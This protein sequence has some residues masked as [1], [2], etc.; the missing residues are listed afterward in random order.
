MHYFTQRWQHLTCALTAYFRIYEA[1]PAV[2]AGF[3]AQQIHAILQLTPLTMLANALNAL[4][5][6]VI[7]FDSPSFHYVVLWVAVLGYTLFKGTRAWLLQR[8]SSPPERVSPRALTRATQ[9]AAALGIIWAALPILV[10]SNTDAHLTLLLISICVGMLC[11]G[12]FALS[13]VPQAAMAYVLL[14]ALGCVIAFIKDGIAQNWD[15]ALLLLIYS[16]IVCSAVLSSA[17][18]FGARL[19]AEAEAAHQQQLVS[20]LLHD[21]ESHTS[22][23]LWELDHQGVLR[24][25]SQKLV[26]LLGQDATALTQNSFAQLFDTDYARN[27]LVDNNP[28]A[29]LEH[30]LQ[31]QEPFRELVIPIV[32]RGERYWWQLTA[33][34]LLNNKDHFVGWRGV[35]SDVTHKRNAELEMRRLANVDSLTNLAN[36]H[37]FYMQLETLKKQDQFSPFTLFFLDL[38]NFKNVNDSLGH[39]VGDLVLKTVAQR[40][41][42]TVR[43]NDLLA[44]LGGDEFAIISQGEDSATQASILAQRILNTFSTPCVINGKSLPIACSIGIALAPDHGRDTETL[45]KNADMALYAAKSAGRNT[46]RF[47]EHGME[48]VAQQ[49][50]YLLND[51]RAALEEHAATNK[52]LNKNFS[53][54]LVWPQTP[55]V[56][57][58]ELFFQPQVKLSTH[59]VVGFEALIRWHHPELGLIPPAQ[60]IPL[61]EESNLIIPIGTWVLVEACKYAAKWP[62]KWRIAVNL[63]AAQFSEGNVIEVVRWALQISRLE[64]AR[65]ELEITE[66]LLIHDN[67]SAQETLTALRKLGVR[68]ALDDFGTGYSSLAYLRTFPLNKLKIDRSFVSALSQDSS[69]LAIVNAIIQL[70]DALELDTT[71]EGIETQQEADILRSCGCRDAQGFYFSKPLPLQEALAQARQLAP[72]VFDVDRM[73]RK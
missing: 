40:L 53:E 64:P 4:A 6:L 63:S 34:P 29:Q 1:E 18:T 48:I 44:R 10:F 60:F 31:R 66:S 7:F 19:M 23:W 2:A 62:E 43:S 24:N 21:F 55:I 47:Y 3:R 32:I 73:R 20:L 28:I 26:S 52:L 58:F 37:C 56:G 8:N 72:P 61:A 9:H 45:L 70:A 68:I 69:A 30:H 38:D 13:T 22:D 27:E 67:V 36:R 50:L 15:L 5:L 42:K 51:M 49:K 39:G 35:G 11:A 33:K 17:K 65:L 25:P 57:Q 12:G 46:F 71:V 59:Q 16:F 14:V 41:L 54:D